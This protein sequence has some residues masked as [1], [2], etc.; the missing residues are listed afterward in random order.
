MPYAKSPIHSGLYG[1]VETCE[2]DKWYQK[3]VVSGMKT[4]SDGTKKA[5]THKKWAKKRKSQYLPTHNMP[6]KSGIQTKQPKQKSIPAFKGGSNPDLSMRHGHGE[7]AH[8]SESQLRSE[9]RSQAISRDK[10]EKSY[11]KKD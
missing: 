2:F 8:V 3:P 7:A 6:V 5:I 10:L 9:Q 1:N 4:E 11:M